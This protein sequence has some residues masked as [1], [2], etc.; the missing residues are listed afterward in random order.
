MSKQWNDYK[1]IW[2]SM[3]TKRSD[4]IVRVLLPIFVIGMGIALSMRDFP[5]SQFVGELTIYTGIA[6]ILMSAIMTSGDFMQTKMR[7][8]ETDD[9]KSAIH[10]STEIHQERT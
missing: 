8:Q 2:Q 1:R 5:L 6:L 7:L 3:E 9:H 4:L 10:S